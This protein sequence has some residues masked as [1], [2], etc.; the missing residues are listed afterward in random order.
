MFT[1]LRRTTTRRIHHIWLP[2]PRRRSRIPDWLLHAKHLQHSLHWSGRY[3]SH[4]SHGCASVA[5][6]QQEQPEL[7]T[8]ED[9]TSDV[10]GCTFGTRD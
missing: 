8:T 6:L 5:F 9:G 2:L 4:I 3:S 10:A 1:G 7:A